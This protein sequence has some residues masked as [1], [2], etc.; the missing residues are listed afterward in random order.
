MPGANFFETILYVFKVEKAKPSI[1]RK[2]QS[3]K[4]IWSYFCLDGKNF[5]KN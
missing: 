3:F 1:I 4:T 5:E 2:L